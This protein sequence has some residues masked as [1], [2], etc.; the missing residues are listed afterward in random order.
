MEIRLSVLS[1]NTAGTGR[2]LAEFGWSVLIEVD[3]RRILFDTGAGFSACHNAS[4]TGID[5]GRLE[6]TIAA[7]KEFAVERL[8]LCHCTGPKATARLSQEFQDRF[9]FC[10]AG[11]VHE[12]P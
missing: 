4:V 7:L 3:G 8:G 2:V 1:E 12:F 10:N 11:T 9:I 5:L 6:K